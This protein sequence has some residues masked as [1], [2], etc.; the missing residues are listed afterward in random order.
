MKCQ[1][2]QHGD[3]KVLESREIAESSIRRRRQ[4][5]DCSYRFTTYERVEVPALSI[6]KKDGTC[7]LYDRAKLQ[8]GIQKAVEKRPVKPAQVKAVVA[9]I[10]RDIFERGE[11]EVSSRVLGELVMER[12]RKLDD[13]AYVRFASVYRRFTSVDSFAKELAK[14]KG[15]RHAKI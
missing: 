9:G 5:L 12:L 2:C 4:C 1:K 13:V 7:E 14:M 3:S 11:D 15:S 10:E 6:V 8:S